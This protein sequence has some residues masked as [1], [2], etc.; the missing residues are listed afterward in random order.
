MRSRGFAEFIYVRKVKCIGNCKPP[1]L[2][3]LFLLKNDSALYICR[4]KDCDIVTRIFRSEVIACCAD[5]ARHARFFK[6]LT[7][8][9]SSNIFA[10]FDN[11]AWK[12]PLP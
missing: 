12:I 6:Y 1:R 2:K 3:Y 10:I 5:Q 11:T 9:S 4:I 8:Q 7:S